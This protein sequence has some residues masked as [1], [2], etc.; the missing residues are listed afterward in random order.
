MDTDTLIRDLMKAERMPLEKLTRKKQTLEWQRDEYRNV[1][2]LLT[3]LRNMS[4]DMRLQGTYFS[5]TTTSSSTSVSA[6]ANASASEGTYNVKVERL[7]TAAVRVSQSSISN[8]PAAKVDPNAKLSTQE[9]KFNSGFDLNADGMIEFSL[10]SYNENGTKNQPAPFVFDPTQVSLND[11]L[12]QI[13]DS[14]LGVR[15]F[16]DATADK[17]VMERTKTGNFN[18]TTEFLG[19]EIGYNGTTA[20][21]LAN[22]LQMKAGDNSTGTWVS[23][24]TGGTNAKF[25]YNGVL[26]VEPP[27]NQYTINNITFNFSEATNTEE[28]ITI[29]SNTDKAF[30]SI[31]QFVK[32]YNEVIE[33]LNGKISEEKFRSYQPLTEEEK[34]A[35]TEKQVELWEE[36]A[37]SGLLRSDTIISS[38]LNQ[39][40]VNIYTPHSG[41]ID[42]YKQLSDLGIS[43]SSNYRDAGKLSVNETELRNKLRENPEAVWQLFGLNGNTNETKGIA[44]RLQETIDSTIKKIENRAGNNLRTN[45]QFGIGR[46]LINVDRQINRFEDRLVQ[47]EDRY[48]KQFSA[49]EKAI[50]KSNQQSMYLMQQ[51]SLGM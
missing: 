19:A 32:K 40:R 22:T 11:V 14:S 29:S 31:M 24:E 50:Q 46:N 7:A 1:N 43:S 35:M 5:K 27:T 3:E 2:K 25:T 45:Q 12:K 38:G 17:V 15:A 16:Y 23:T 39:M 20:S 47:V 8:N 30:D 42:G 48:W 9:G 21:F 4:F 26:T 13:N 28:T 34:E 44:R 51:F 33:N 41:A 37:K 10:V 36:R 18:Q 6:T 49:M